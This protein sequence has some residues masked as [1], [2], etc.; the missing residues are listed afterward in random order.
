MMF[1][2]QYLN[3]RATITTK[4]FLAAVDHHH[5]VQYAQI[6]L[7]VYTDIQLASESAPKRYAISL[8]IH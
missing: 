7:F 3:S 4:L 2:V 8:K 5:L 6:P 1:Q